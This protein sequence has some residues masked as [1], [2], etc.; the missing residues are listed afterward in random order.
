MGG[1]GPFTGGHG[2]RRHRRAGPGLG[3]GVAE[4]ADR[5]LQRTAAGRR[6]AA[7][8]AAGDGP[9]ADPRRRRPHVRC[10]RGDAAASVA[11]RP[12]RG[13]RGL[14]RLGPAGAGDHR[15]RQPA[16]PSGAATAEAKALRQAAAVHRDRRRAVGAAA[17]R[18]LPLAGDPTACR[19]DEPAQ[20]RR[21]ARRH[22][23]GLPIGLSVGRARYLQ[24][25]G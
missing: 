24:G 9:A 6:R 23:R 19:P 11:E 21:R 10:R 2:R 13:V 8:R 5:R 3:S 20:H 7:R 25:P 14:P 18:D 12:G 17:V 15:P 22:R 16:A 1:G 4:G